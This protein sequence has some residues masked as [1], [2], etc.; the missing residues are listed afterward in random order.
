MKGNGTVI[1]AL[2]VTAAALTGC[3]SVDAAKDEAAQAHVEGLSDVLEAQQLKN[4]REAHETISDAESSPESKLAS[5]TDP[6]EAKEQAIA[7]G[8]PEAAWDKYCVAWE[9]PEPSSADDQLV[10]DV[11][12][13]YLDHH[14]AA[15]PDAIVHPHY[16]AD[17]FAAGEPGEIIITLEDAA[18]TEYFVTPN[19][20]GGL[21]DFGFGFFEA[22]LD[23]HPELEMVT[24]TV[25][26]TD[27]SWT[28]TPAQ[29]E[30]GVL[31]AN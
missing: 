23:S 31:T 8:R 17:S 9:L 2:A 19:S 1:A 18:L 13:T 25:D 3:G 30:N 12:Q 11:T 10:N 15:C 27:R 7:D 6:A 28:A 29:Y 22:T 24:V 4:D 14:D 20:D 5:I 21:Q 16:H 26:G